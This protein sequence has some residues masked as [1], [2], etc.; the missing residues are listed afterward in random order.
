[1]L[2]QSPPKVGTKVPVL[3]DIYDDGKNYYRYSLMDWQLL[4]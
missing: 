2:Q 1:M 3:V 4:K